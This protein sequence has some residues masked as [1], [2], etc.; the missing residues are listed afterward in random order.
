VSSFGFGGVN[1]HVVIEEYVPP[2][3]RSAGVLPPRGGEALIV[4]SA[5]NADQLRERAKLLHAA[6]S[7]GALDESQLDSIAYTLQVGRDPMEERLGFAVSSLEELRDKLAAYLQRGTAPGKF[8]RGTV[9]K[10]DAARR[11]GEGAGTPPPRGADEW[12]ERWVQGAPLEWARLYDDAPTSPHRVPLPTYPFA[13]DRC[14]VEPIKQ[15][16]PRAPAAGGRR[17]SFDHGALSSLLD[18]FEMEANAGEAASR[19]IKELLGAI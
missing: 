15:S 16:P 19:E 8:Y 10:A 7:R 13:R 11:A 9:N 17:R 18:R 3:P 6:L 1:A 12:L 2:L 14:W 4:L 5:K